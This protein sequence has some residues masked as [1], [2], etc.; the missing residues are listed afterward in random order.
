MRCILDISRTVARA[1]LPAATGIDRVERAYARR[2]IAGGATFLCRAGDRQHLLGGETVR[3]LLDWLDGDGPAPAG[4]LAAR[5]PWRDERLARARALVRREAIG[6]AAAFDPAAIRALLRRPGADVYLNVGHANLDLPTMRGAAAAGLATAVLLHDLIPLENAAFAS[7]TAPERAR[8]TLQAAL[9][10]DLVVCNSSDTRERLRRA[11]GGLLP[12]TVVAPLGID[13]PS[14]PARRADGVGFVCLGTIEPRKN[15]ALLLDVW[16]RLWSIYGDASPRLHII[17]RRGWRSEA[18]FRRLDTEPFMGRSVIEHGPLTDQ[19]AVRLLAAATALLFPSRAEGFGLPLGEALALGVPV[20]ASDLPALRELG[21]EVPEW[22]SPDAASDWERAV[23]D[24]AARPSARGE[25]QIA[26]LASWRPPS[27]R[28]HFRI[29][30]NA[31]E[32]IMV[33]ASPGR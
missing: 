25:A 28:E 23:V 7:A 24:Y 17:G 26:R 30:G 21:G 13:V 12:Q 4:G 32:S 19:A 15:H 14:R 22:L 2:A 29:V 33:Q 10:A 5:L 20:I 11:G 3:A 27:W 8:A 6:T 18:L 9:G 31:L 16:A 1:R